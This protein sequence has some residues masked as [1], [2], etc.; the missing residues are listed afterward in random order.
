MRVAESTA[1]PSASHR[2]FALLVG[3]ALCIRLVAFLAL[4]MWS[5]TAIETRCG[6][7]HGW[8]DAAQYQ[9]MAKGLV[10]TG[11]FSAHTNVLKGGDQ[12]EWHPVQDGHQITAHRLPGYP[13]FLWP[14]FGIFPEHYWA[15]FIAQ[16]FV[17]ALTC[18]FVF[19]ISLNAFRHRRAAILASVL[20]AIDPIAIHYS[21]R[22]ITETLF[23]FLVTVSLY[24]CVRSFQNQAWK[25]SALA[26]LGLGVATLVKPIALYFGAIP[27]LCIAL[28][29]KRRPSKALRVGALLACTSLVLLPW[30]ERNRQEFGHFKLSNAAG[31]T[32]CW[33][34][35]SLD[36]QHFAD[37]LAM[38]LGG[39][40]WR[41][42][43][44]DPFEMSAA[45]KQRALQRIGQNFTQFSVK[46]I[47]GALKLHQPI[48]PEHWRTF[49]RP[50]VNTTPLARALETIEP[51]L[52]LVIH[53]IVLALAALGFLIT[54]TRPRQRRYAVFFAL[55][56]GYFLGAVGILG[57]LAD[58]ARFRLPVIPLYM[59]FAATAAHWLLEHFTVFIHSKRQTT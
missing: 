10:E 32:L 19:L 34:A 40:D 37:D 15:A 30:M 9:A 24:L 29:G 49:D 4:Q 28:H 52:R 6:L 56:I 7:Y 23:T 58:T 59:I 53:P 17:D 16:A 36:S 33:Q 45:A 1:A 21:Q 20:Y 11:T 50:E 39:S 43:S 54:L 22:L 18:G 5:C 51:F 55:T 26:G 46:H 57:F 47:H 3:F 12:Y 25:S 2:T 8:D 42:A 41:Y 48:A 27:A 44:K 14:L 35:S 31:N 13:L 38:C